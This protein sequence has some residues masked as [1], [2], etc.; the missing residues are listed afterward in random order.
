MIKKPSE[1]TIQ[2]ELMPMFE[3][4][5]VL[6]EISSI[7]YDNLEYVKG[8]SKLFPYCTFHDNHNYLLPT[9]GVSASE[10]PEPPSPS[11]FPRAGRGDSY[12][13]SASTTTLIL[14]A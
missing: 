10:L 4:S 2:S 1:N 13:P 5:L 6:Y 14:R 7:R 8:Y 9:L 11:H 3:N 12:H